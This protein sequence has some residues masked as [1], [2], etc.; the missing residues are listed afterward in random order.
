LRPAEAAAAASQGVDDAEA[1]R[2]DDE[3]KVVEDDIDDN[4]KEPDAI[5]DD[6]KVGATDGAAPSSPN[7]SSLSASPK[8]LS[9]EAARR[10]RSWPCRSRCCC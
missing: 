3:P 2:D 7:P 5:E 10:S 1:D 6:A 9:L 8:L 4:A